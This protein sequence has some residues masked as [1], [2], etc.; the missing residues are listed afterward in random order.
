[1]TLPAVRTVAMSIR[2]TLR[3]IIRGI[4]I[5]KEGLEEVRGREGCDYIE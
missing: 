2:G 1:M 3:R 5:D 4:Y